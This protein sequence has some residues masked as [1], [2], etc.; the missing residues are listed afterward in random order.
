MGLRLR[1][2]RGDTRRA[3]LGLAVLLVALGEEGGRMLGVEVIGFG[4]VRACVYVGACVC[5][6]V[7]VCVACCECVL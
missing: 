2:E 6:C 1:E 5:G 7:D 3:L 4:L